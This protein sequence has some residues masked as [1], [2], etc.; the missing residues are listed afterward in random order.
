MTPAH[1]GGFDGTDVF[2]HPQN[3]PN[4]HPRRHAHRIGALV[5]L[6]YTR[7][8]TPFFR[9]C[10]DT[11]PDTEIRYLDLVLIKEVSSD[12]VP[13]NLA[14]SYHYEHFDW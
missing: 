8:Q 3:H 6:F 14:E 13:K 4:G 9:V 5:A 10:P 11:L 2:N 7:S 1:S 12:L